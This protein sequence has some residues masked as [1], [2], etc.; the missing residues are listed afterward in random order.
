MNIAFVLGNGKSRQAVNVD[1]LKRTGM[2]YSCN[3]SYRDFTP[4][5]LV[6]TDKGISEEIQNSG[7]ATRHLFYTRK[8]LANL[9]AHR[10]DKS[11]Y[12]FSS[13]PIAIYYAAKDHDYVYFLGFDLGGIQ[14]KF[15]NIYADSQWYKK[16]SES[17]TFAGNWVNQISK[18]I[19]EH[20]NTRFIRVT[21]PESTVISNFF[22]FKNFTEMSIEHFLL[23]INKS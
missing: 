16:S 9:G 6:A 18:I 19:Q 17:E 12:G 23:E 13:G 22:K 5:V 15:N 4:D 21:G 8:P 7:Y 14:G 1:Q 20:T 10:I 3:A 2:V 11:V